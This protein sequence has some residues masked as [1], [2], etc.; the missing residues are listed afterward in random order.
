MV[1]LNRKNFEQFEKASPGSVILDDEA[2]T[3]TLIGWQLEKFEDTGTYEEKANNIECNSNGFDASGVSGNLPVGLIEIVEQKLL[4]VGVVNPFTNS[5]EK[6]TC[7][8]HCS[9][10]SGIGGQETTSIEEKH[11]GASNNQHL[12]PVVKGQLR[13]RIIHLFHRVFKR[14]KAQ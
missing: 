11:E 1:G 12:I 2:G 9:H 14:H 13:Q 4:L 10:C 6:D 5:P 8:E 3:V 7:R